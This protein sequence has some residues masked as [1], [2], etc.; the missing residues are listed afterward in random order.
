MNS[1]LDLGIRESNHTY[2]SNRSSW[3]EFSVYLI[4]WVDFWVLLYVSYLVILHLY[5][6]SWVF[7]YLVFVLYGSCSV[8][9]RIQFYFVHP[10]RQGLT[11]RVTLL[12]LPFIGWSYV[13]IFFPNSATWD[14]CHSYSRFFSE[15]SFY[16]IC[17][18]SPIDELLGYL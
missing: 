17:L 4:F 16:K 5:K 2:T 14:E 1:L 7:L 8:S 15:L 12:D 9:C 13:N 10:T 3:V 6:C 18:F 11:L